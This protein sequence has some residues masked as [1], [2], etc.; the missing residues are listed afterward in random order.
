MDQKDKL[1]ISNL[2]YRA[3]WQDVKEFFG[4]YGEVA[5]V[6]LLMDRDT[7]RP[8][9]NGFVTF[10]SPE[11]AAKALEEANGVEFMGREVSVAYARPREE[12]PE[13]EGSESRSEMEESSEE[14]EMSMDMSESEDME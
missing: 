2:N 4:Q 11:A 3:S 1:Y 8:R 9:G 12:K 7:N 6:K 10:E 5:F 13:Y 14:S